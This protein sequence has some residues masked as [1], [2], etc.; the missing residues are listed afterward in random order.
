MAMPEDRLSTV[1]E[2][3]TYLPP[4]GYDRSLL[5]DK[6]MGPV[7]LGNT[8][9]GNAF[10]VWHMTYSDPD[11]IL[12]PETQ[13]APLTTP[14]FPAVAGVTE[15]S[16]C[17][18]Q[19]GNITIVYRAGGIVS[20][21]WFDTQINDYTTTASVEGALSAMVCLDD[22]RRTQTQFNDVLVFYTKAVAETYVLHMRRQR[23][24]FANEFDLV[25]PC[26]RY[27]WKVGMHE[28]LR[29]QFITID[30]PPT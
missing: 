3:A 8:S 24:R 17:F 9:G 20:L 11:F 27:V 1:P 29:L 16:F 7:G 18:D 15:L 23:D 12:T 22:K 13:G 30:A 25:L 21:Y 19:N 2:P 6:E 5:D 14:T 26:W 10:Q 4:D 28:S